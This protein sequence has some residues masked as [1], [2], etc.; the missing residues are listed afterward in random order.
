MKTQTPICSD[1][2]LFYYFVMCLIFLYTTVPTV[3]IFFVILYYLLCR[4]INYNVPTMII[5][6]SFASVI[7]AP[8]AVHNV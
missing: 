8:A 5:C 6:R 7:P 4:F 3:I 2:S 1:P